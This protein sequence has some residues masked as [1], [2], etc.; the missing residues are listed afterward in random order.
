M[1]KMNSQLSSK[2]RTLQEFYLTIYPKESQVFTTQNP[3]SLQVYYN[4]ACHDLV[5]RTVS[6]TAASLVSL[7]VLTGEYPIIRFYNPNEHDAYFNASILPKMIANEFQNK[8][9][10]YARNHSDFPPES[11]RQRSIFVITDRTLDLFSPLLHEF[12]YQAMAYDLVNIDKSDVYKYQAENEKGEKESK[13]AKLNDE[14]EDWCKLRHLHI[15]DA[16]TALTSRL[17]EF[18]SKNQMLVDRSNI[19]STSDILTAVARLSGFDEERRRIILHKTLVEDLLL[20]NGE[21][22]LTELADFEQDLANFGYNID[23][24]RVKNLAETL[25]NLLTKEYYGFEDKLRTIILYGLYRGGLVEEDYI[26]LI[27]LIGVEG[28]YASD[29][30]DFIKNFDQIGFKLIKQNLKSKSVFKREFLHDSVSEG[31]YSSSRFQPAINNVISRIISHTLDEELFVYVKDKPID[32]DNDVT[33][34]S[35]TSTSSLKNPRHKASWARSNSNYQAP[36]QRIFYFISGGATH[37][38]M[39]TAYELSLKFDKEVIIGSDEILTPN[40]FLTNVK[41]LSVSERRELNLFQDWKSRYS[42]QSAP[43]V[44]LETPKPKV[45][46]QTQPQITPNPTSQRPQQQHLNTRIEPSS[47]IDTKESKRSRFKKFLKG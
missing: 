2:L 4:T 40:Q 27:Q 9:D 17:E 45:I 6:K 38:E 1:I 41:N 31:S 7:C 37:S 43:K 44:L 26:K 34:T 13:E 15:I 18:L 32:L 36:K 3:S 46:N 24:E 30:L 42:N 22:K 14:D 33:R 29:V 35:S 11:P 8:L 47:S 12:T 28:H 21:K 25:L 5:T 10:E 20:V 39:R 23:G 16:Q 19:K